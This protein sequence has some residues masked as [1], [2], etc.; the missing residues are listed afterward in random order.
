MTMNDYQELFQGLHPGFFQEENIR[1]LPED[2]VFTELIMDL[3]EPVP[4]VPQLHF[5]G[6]IIFGEYHG[7]IA[8]LRDTVARVEEG[9]VRYFTE[10]NRYYC[11]FD[12]E[13]IVAFCHLSDMGRIRGLHIGGPGCV[14]TIPEYRRQGIG[15]E[16]VRRATEIFRREGFDFS[17]IHY[18]DLENWYRKLGYR[19]VLW[20][21]SGGFCRAAE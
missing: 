16:M 9:W 10:G 14:G 19:P 21:N 11:A 13:K 6:R 5:P 15:L 2:W 20:W 7:E 3:H 18:T 12:G 8:A 1:T 17:W 4:D